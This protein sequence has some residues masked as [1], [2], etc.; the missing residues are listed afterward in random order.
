MI[1]PESVGQAFADSRYVQIAPAAKQSGGAI[2]VQ[3]A[4]N[5]A[6]TFQLNQ[7]GTGESDFFVLNT[8]GT[9]DLFSVFEN[10]LTGSPYVQFMAKT[11]TFDLLAGGTFEII[12]SSA[13]MLFQPDD[14]VHGDS[15]YLGNGAGT[16]N[17]GA[18]VMVGYRAGFNNTTGYSVMAGFQAG[19]S[20]TTGYS[21]MVGFN[22]GYSNTTVS[23]VMVGYQ[24]GF[25]NTT[26]YSVMAGFQAG[27]SNTTGYSVMAGYQAGF[28]N[29]TGYSVMAGFQAGFSNTTGNI[30]AIGYQAGYTSVAGNANTT[31]NFNDYFGYNSGPG[32]ATQLSYSGAIGSQAV[33]LASNLIVVGAQNAVNGATATVGLATPGGF[34]IGYT[35]Q[36]TAPALM[37]LT[38]YNTATIAT[39]RWQATTGAALEFLD[40]GATNAIAAGL[41]TSAVTVGAGYVFSVASVSNVSDAR[42]KTGWTTKHGF[43]LLSELRAAKVGSYTGMDLS[44]L[45]EQFSPTDYRRRVLGVD[46]NS[47]PETVTQLT[48]EGVRGILSTHFYGWVVGTQ[49]ALLDKI[50]QLEERLRKLE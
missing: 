46:A 45:G 17:T 14:L 16:N 15:V 18:S 5:S 33:V 37:S 41:F 50:D 12:N 6:L 39:V 32:T 22:A 11:V 2:N 38:Y 30:T 43:D 48:P 36:T 10:G 24:A 42:F 40:T 13:V 23:S 8:A 29:T 1:I 21:V 47:L 27:Y 35:N 44:H 7:T 26:G 20:N 49:Q 28:S 4:P 9:D 3:A 19:F 31:G 25:N 34:A